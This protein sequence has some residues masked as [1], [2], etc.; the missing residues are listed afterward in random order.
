MTVN[1]G[2]RGGGIR[3]NR[4]LIVRENGAVGGR[5]LI[6]IMLKV[7]IVIC[8]LHHRIAYPGVHF[9]PAYHVAVFFVELS[10]FF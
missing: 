8:R 5:L 3:G 10:V 4:H 7:K 1:Y 2:V 9:Y 6:K